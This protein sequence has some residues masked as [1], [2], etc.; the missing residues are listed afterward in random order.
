MCGQILSSFAA[1]IDV[2][3]LIEGNLSPSSGTVEKANEKKYMSFQPLIPKEFYGL[4][5][6]AYLT[7]QVPEG[8]ARGTDLDLDTAVQ[9]V[10]DN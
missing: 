10:R 4:S 6:E 8:A 5:V 2:L 1:K 3:K 9:E 7:Q